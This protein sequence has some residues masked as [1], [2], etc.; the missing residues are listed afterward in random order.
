MRTSIGGFISSKGIDVTISLITLV[1]V[2]LGIFLG[3]S[4][5]KSKED[6]FIFTILL[7]ANLYVIFWTFISFVLCES[8]LVSALRCL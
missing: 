8:S 5:I 3:I 2:V 6:F 7:L 1:S 4:L